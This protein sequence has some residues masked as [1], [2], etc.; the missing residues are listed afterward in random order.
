M[1]WLAEDENHF[2]PEHF[3]Q[4]VSEFSKEFYERAKVIKKA[5][6]FFF[7]IEDTAGA[8]FGEANPKLDRKFIVTQPTYFRTTG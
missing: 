5:Q 1:Q 7:K 6:D 4:L 8:M 3:C 2:F